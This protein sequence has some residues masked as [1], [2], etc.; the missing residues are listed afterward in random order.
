MLQKLKHEG[1]VKLHSV[2]QLSDTRIIMMMEHIKGGNL[3]DYVKYK[4]D[5]LSDEEI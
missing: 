4:N 2:F 1:I 3:L 5:C